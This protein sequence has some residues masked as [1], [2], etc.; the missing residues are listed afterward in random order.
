MTRQHALV[1]LLLSLFNADGLRRFVG[2]DSVLC[3]LKDELPDRSVSKIVLVDALVVC[4]CER[5]LVDSSF[6]IRLRDNRPGRTPEIDEVE[7]FWGE[8]CAPKPSPGGGRIVFGEGAT[9]VIH[10]DQVIGDK[11]VVIHHYANSRGAGESGK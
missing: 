6:F 3:E 9:F 2:F 10:G 8:P 11:Q 7:H 1:T 5:G 4:L